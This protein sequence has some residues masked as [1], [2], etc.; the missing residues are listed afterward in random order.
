METID[1]SADDI[2]NKPNQERG[3]GLLRVPNDH[4]I[5]PAIGKAS[6]RVLVNLF[7]LYSLGE[8]STRWPQTNH[9]KGPIETEDCCHDSRLT[10]SCTELAN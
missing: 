1:H 8:F 3:R 4:T 2:S 7:H 6:F 9:R 5:G 10:S